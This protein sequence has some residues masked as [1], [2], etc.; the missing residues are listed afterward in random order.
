MRHEIQEEISMM[1]I[2]KV[3]DSYQ[4]ALKAEDKLAR[5]QIQ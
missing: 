1:S 2:I 5:K 3:E 4:V